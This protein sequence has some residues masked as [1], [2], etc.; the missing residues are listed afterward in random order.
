MYIPSLI[1]HED[2]LFGGSLVLD[3]RKRWRHVNWKRSIIAIAAI[4]ETMR[5]AIE[6]TVANTITA[7]HDGKVPDGQPEPNS[8]YVVKQTKSC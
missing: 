3:F 8:V 4:Y 7:V 5:L 2:K 6:N 1:P